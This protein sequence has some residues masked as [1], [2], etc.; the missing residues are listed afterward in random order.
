MRAAE[1][2]PVGDGVCMFT[3]MVLLQ[4]KDEEEVVSLLRAGKDISN[5]QWQ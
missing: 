4:N 1:F 2:V 3:W 5:L